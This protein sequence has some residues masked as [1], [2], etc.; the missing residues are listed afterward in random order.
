METNLHK[1][2]NEF[3]PL[4]GE[5]MNSISLGQ[6]FFLRSEITQEII[7]RK[8][9][10]FEKWAL[11]TFLLIIFCLIIG[12][13]F[14]KYPD[15]IE[16]TAILTG[17]NAPKEIIPKQ[18]GKLVALL[19][20]NN[21]RVKRGEILGFI[22]SSADTKEVFDLSARLDSSVELAQVNRLSNVVKLFNKRY[23]HLGELQISYQ[24]F[25]NARQQYSDYFVNN[26]Y[27]KRREMLVADINTLSDIKK[28]VTTQ[29]QLT[30]E[31]NAL[32]KLSF[33]MNKRLYD[34]KVIS[35]EE[36]RQA[37]RELLN[38]QLSIPQSNVNIS[39]QDNQIRDKKKEID[40]IDH[41]IFLQQQT[42]EQAVF[43]LKGAVDE[44]LNKYTI[45]A[46]ADG[47]VVFALPLQQ[48]Q[49]VEQGK[50]LG[51][52]NPTDSRYFAEIRLAQDNIGK[53]D[54]GMKVQL[55]FYAY[56]YQEN[57]YLSGTLDYISNVPV[58]DSFW[59][60]IRLDNGLVTN[61]RKSISY[62]SGLK[63]KAFVITKD[64]RLP[65]RL[66]YSIVKTTS[67]NK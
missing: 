60:T 31:D 16:G 55:R 40:Q 61:Q 10:A 48:N 41:D 57:G 39:I 56:P 33:E 53:I 27:R 62:K 49:Y 42:F 35:A 30:T 29:K 37:Q 26:F 44:W 8:P 5:D 32:A 50:L 24:A 18:S 6:N 12:T 17:G 15:I 34:E 47:V 9:G 14:I 2:T 46:P 52:V 13:W 11:L 3:A 43:N 4:S 65:E 51:Y 64:M 36:F 45:P 59:G 66:Y 63:A 28:Q 23:T 54:T 25:I 21:Q 22:E 20:K 38:K 1:D 7:S 19:V 67:I 58:A